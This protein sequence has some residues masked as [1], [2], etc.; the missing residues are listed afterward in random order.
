MADKSQ[1]SPP[2][3]R[4]GDHAIVIG[5]SLAGLFAARVLA[6]SYDRVTIVERDALPA[7]GAH[8][9][10]VP[11]D[12]HAHAY[13]PG[14]QLAVKQLFPTFVEDVVAAGALPFHAGPDLRVT[15]SGHPLPRM[16]SRARL[17][18]ASR[19]VFEGVVRDRVRALANV[20]IRERCAVVGLIGEHGRVAGVRTRDVAQAGAERA[21][22][23][24]LVVAASGRGGRVPGW[25]RAMG[26]DAPAE[27]RVAIDLHYVSRTL[28][29][30]PG[31]LA[32]EKM[33][34]DDARPDR[35]R[36]M[37]MIKE[38][39]GERWTL[40]LQGYGDGR[41]PADEAGFAAYAASVAAPDVRAAIEQAEPLGAIASHAFPAGLR[42]RYDK[43]RRFPE[44]LLVMGD[45]LCSFNPVYG[46]GMSVAALEA[47]ALQRCLRDGDRRLARRF[48]AAAN[49]PVEH[50]WKLSTGSDLAKPYVAGRAALPDRIVSRYMER[51]LSVAEHDEGVARAFGEVVAMLA[52]P[53]RLFAPAVA[54]RVLRRGATRRPVAVARPSTA[55]LGGA[56]VPANA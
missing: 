42:R 10:A 40:T 56:E 4:L 26:Y 18:T 6:D 23:A 49:V 43:L 31:A 9:R 19:P 8:R 38:A 7:L 28:R 33:I 34:V 48:F 41:P 16:R 17:A 27:E 20:E 22:R 45:A 53:S 51:L 46:Q 24:D 47:L 5:A 55:A 14:G 52:P 44:G 39:G 13:Q 30:R 25:L 54:R 32:G 37:F 12:R 35:P 3:P 36:G 11:Q 21:L 15:A 1:Q 50:A 29:L 2:A